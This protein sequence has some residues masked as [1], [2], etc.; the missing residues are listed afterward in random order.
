[1]NRTLLAVGL[2]TA[3][4]GIGYAAANLQ[5]LYYPLR[6]AD[7]QFMAVEPLGECSSG[8][9]AVTDAAGAE[10][11]QCWTVYGRVTARPRR[12]GLAPLDCEARAPLRRQDLAKV[13][14][15]LNASLLPV[16]AG[17]HGVAVEQ[18]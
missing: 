8:A 4:A 2:L 15:L 13:Q 16:C 3:A 1:V 11:G 18:P 10:T 7:V 12:E 17:R 5:D 6:T 14:A 9:L